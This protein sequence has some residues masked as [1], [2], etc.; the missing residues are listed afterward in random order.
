MLRLLLPVL[1]LLGVVGV[2]V[3]ADRPMPR[4]DF[5]FINRGD[6]TTLDLAV[7]SW[8]QD[9]RIAR[10]LFEGL[11]KND[12]FTDDY[13]VKPAAAERWDVSPDGLV[14]TFHLREGAR[15]SN[16]EP[17][18]AS[19]FAYAWRRLLL[20]DNAGDYA[21]LVTVIKGAGDF[22]AWRT[23]ALS[24]FAKATD[25]PD[26]AEAGQALWRETLAR[27]DRTVG[28]TAVDDRTLRVELERPT[29]Y[30]LDLTSFAA[31]YP[32]YRPLVEA[33]ESIDPRTAR[34]RT[35]PDW[36]KPPKLVCN[37]PFVLSVWRFKRDM[38]FEQNPHYW[39]R[40]SLA[41][42]T[43]AIPS[44]Q[45]GNAQV[46]AFRTGAVDWVSDVTPGY[47]AD[48]L[49]AK[50][51]F[52]REHQVE[53]DRL[54]ALGLDAQDIDRA[55]P[56]DPRKNIHAFPAF[57]TYF[58]NFNCLPRLPDGRDNPMA[59]RRVRRALAMAIDKDSLVR[60]VRR[61]GEPVARTLIPPNSIAGYTSPK[62][63]GYDPAAAR[64]LLAEAG[65]PGGKGLGP[66]EILFNKDGGH[67]LIAQAIARD[68][69]ENL[70]VAVLLSMKEVK[71]FRDDLKNANFMTSRASWFGD[72]GD[73]TTFL[74]L[75]ETDDGNNDRKYSSPVF[76]A[77][78]QKA[79]EEPDATKRL[80]VL[81]EA[82]RLI[83][84]EDLPLVPLF[85]YEQV[86]LFDAD[87]LSGISPHPRQEQ[88]MYLMDILGDGR[89]PDVPRSMRRRSA[90]AAE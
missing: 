66:V 2:T 22:Y 63:L 53:Y 33:Y 11:T 42:R 86:Y 82:E 29:P 13:E 40:E 32:T 16:G 28:I 4:A 49:A 56:S 71:V 89:G 61:G 52:Y 24:D 81:T 54:V 10:F 87:K 51:A 48:I 18:L 9:F 21:K 12:I 58:Y 83:V 17:L 23:R 77:L 15:W 43:I 69:T 73:P 67:D 20:P 75:N 19:D 31:F 60:N 30:F 79:R 14:Y 3:V 38:R 8:Q 74:N 46:M 68:W 78:L 57:G 80:A 37:G 35:K 45:D 65:Y 1:V 34:V 47:R 84:E 25:V 59:D 7:M 44:V 5:T 6:V 64:A 88:N 27:F 85:T 90:V 26:R 62:G 76:D 39:N 50:R 55:L 36:T 70:G 41:V 72:Y